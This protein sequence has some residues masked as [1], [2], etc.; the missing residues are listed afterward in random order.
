MA[1]LL[2][3]VLYMVAMMMTTYDGVLSIIFQPLM[4]ALLTG[5]SLVML[6]IL[7]SPLLL[8]QVWVGWRHLWWIPILLVF[9]GIGAVVV[10]WHP[11]FRIRVFNPDTKTWIDSFQPELAISGWLAAMF[12]VAFCPLIGI[13][14]DRRW[15]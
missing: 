14:G 4:G 9:A 7:G 10:S 11:S 12:G 2:G 8:R 5:L 3:M 15:L 6:C 13:R 1:F